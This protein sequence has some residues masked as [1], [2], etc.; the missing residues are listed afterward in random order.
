MNI[1]EFNALIRLLD[2]PDQQVYQQ[3]KKRLLREGKEVLPLLRREWNKKLKM[4][5]ILKLEDI[6]N[7][8][9][10]TDFNRTFKDWLLNEPNNILQG[11]IILSKYYFPDI[12]EE[13]I[14]QQV[15]DI[16]KGIWLE[17]NFNHTALENIKIFN[18]FFFNVHQFKISYNFKVQN[19]FL[20]KILSTKSGNPIS[21]GMLYSFLAQESGLPVYG[22]N[23]GNKFY[24]AYLNSLSPDVADLKNDEI[25]FYID[26]SS[27]G[28]LFDKASIE[29]KLHKEN[30]H[31]SI[32]KLIPFQNHNFI[33]YWLTYTIVMFQ[34]SGYTEKVE[35]LQQV[36]KLFVEHAITN[37]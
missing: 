18:H 2:D 37:N 35:E 19:T 34:K 22:V 24:L 12:N 13:F 7:A 10:F 16:K 31:K 36:W 32:G 4:D 11:F 1:S 3:V 17:M 14:I 33:R 8:I 28:K 25:L 30:N 20:N 9:N 21:L 23:A 26:P 15:N 6:I 29:K 5:E 27:Y